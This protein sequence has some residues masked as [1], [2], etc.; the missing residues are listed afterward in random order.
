MGILTTSEH[1]QAA[2]SFLQFMLSQEVQSKDLNYSFPVNQAVFDQETTEER[3]FDSYLSFT[4]ADGNN[5]GVQAQYPDA[6]D[7]ENLR[8]WVDNL[9]TPASTDFIIRSTVLD[10]MTACLLKE[11]T[12]EDAAQNAMKTINLYLA[13]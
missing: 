11:I 3:V 10:Q 6:Q 2:G 5:I 8:T 4:D 12:P 1:P 13:E 9:T 7:R